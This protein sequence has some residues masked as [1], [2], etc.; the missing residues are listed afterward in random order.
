MSPEVV[1][2]LF[3][4]FGAVFD[5][6]ALG[7]DKAYREAVAAFNS[8]YRRATDAEQGAYHALVAEFMAA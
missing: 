3:E 2:K 8:L 4:A 5:A 1:E 7:A 6:A